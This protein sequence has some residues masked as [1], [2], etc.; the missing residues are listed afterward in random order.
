VPR[1][2]QL[3]PLLLLAAI[4]PIAG[5]SEP[6]VLLAPP[7]LS[8]EITVGLARELDRAVEAAL[9]ERP[10]D[11][12]GAEELR[13]RGIAPARTR[14][15]ALEIGRR[16]GLPVLCYSARM[17]R[18]QLQ[19]SV[20]LAG[21]G[22]SVTLERELPP[23]ELR[24]V[25][26]Q[27]VGELFVRGGGAPPA[28]RP[29]G[30]GPGAAPAVRR[31]AAPLAGR[32]VVIGLQLGA[33]FALGAG[34]ESLTPGLRVGGAVG[35]QLPLRSRHALTPEVVLAY[36]RWWLVDGATVDVVH[37]T[38]PVDGA[39]G[40]IHALA[41]VRYSAAVG[42][43]ELW[44]AARLGL[45]HSMIVVENE[46]DPSDRL[47][48]GETGFAL[49]GELGAHYMIVPAFGLGLSADLLKSFVDIAVGQRS[50]EEY[51]SIGIGV[52]LSAVGRIPW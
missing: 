18:G 46:H 16:L 35:V 28:A 44:A 38:I 15:Q 42:P 51:S 19:I 33:S 17:A 12:L 32:A 26:A 27:V 48:R 47:E 11:A 6:A 30:G 9:R 50:V 41:G 24:P 22:R 23:G 45:G 34:A 14:G 49:G 4:G 8:D 10:I 3:L 36:S 5:A 2:A 29:T 31:S 37:T 39:F 52:G 43:V 25:V 20:T 1:I 21:P 40:M 7:E 13:A